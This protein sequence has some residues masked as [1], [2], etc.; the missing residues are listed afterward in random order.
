[1]TSIALGLSEEFRYEENR[2]HGIEAGQII[3]LGTDGIWEARNVDGKMFGKERF[4]NI[5]RGNAKE[6]AA[7][8]LSA[9]YS[10][11]DAFSKGNTPEDDITLVVAKVNKN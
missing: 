3:A 7:D 5:I 6:N 10:E 9:V 11:L 1:M 8:I 4:R 2:R